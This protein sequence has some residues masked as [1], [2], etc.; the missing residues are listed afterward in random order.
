MKKNVK[1]IILPIALLLFS[2]VEKYES[3]ISGNNNF[4]IIEGMITDLSEP[5]E[6]VLTRTVDLNDKI[7]IIFETNAIVTISDDLGNTTILNEISEGRYITDPNEF[8]G[9][10]DVNY[11]LTINT[12]D[13]NIY[14]SDPVSLMDVVEIDSVFTTSNIGFNYTTGQQEFGIDIN[15]ATKPWS[16]EDE[17]FLKWDYIETWKLFPTYSVMNNP[18]IPH[19]PCYNII[20]S[21]TIITDNTSQYSTNKIDKKQILYINEN[22]YKPYFGYSIMV[23]QTALNESVYQFWKMLEE[24]TQNN[25]NI[26]DKIP[27]NAIS[28]IYCKNND[29]VKVFGYFNASKVSEKRL[30]FKPPVFGIKFRNFYNSCTPISYTLDDFQIFIQAAHVD[31]SDVFVYDFV[32]D[33]ILFFFNRECVDCS[34]SATTTIKPTY[35]PYN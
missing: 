29:D 5:N 32:E 10:P 9:K 34:Q 21:S 20:K 25:G 2:C 6:V 18:E 27:Y 3:N 4:L 23:R 19:V 30:S 35:W 8:I 15:V 14:E 26:F 13:G 16:E 33:K 28:N 1:I 31:S 22:E 7:S 11:T 17:Y 12:I 24:N